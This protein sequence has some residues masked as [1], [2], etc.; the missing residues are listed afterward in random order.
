MTPDAQQPPRKN[1]ANRCYICGKAFEE[2]ITIQR[3]KHGWKHVESDS[4]CA[5]PHTPAPEPNLLAL[6]NLTVSAIVGY[7]A[8]YADGERTATLATLDEYEKNLWVEL[9]GCGVSREVAD[10]IFLNVRS[11][12]LRQ[13]AG[14][15]E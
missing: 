12:L 9:Q 4:R 13:Q 7:E 15:Q 14:E 10:G 11:K 8:G 5:R 2:G 1:D 6:E 3:D